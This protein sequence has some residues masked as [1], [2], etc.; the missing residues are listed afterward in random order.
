MKT[1]LTL[2]LLCC[3]GF[4]S[5]AQQPIYN[6]DAETI[7]LKTKMPKDWNIST[8]KQ[9]MLAYQVKLDPSVK[10][11]GQTSISIEKTGNQSQFSTISYFIPK[12]FQGSTI[13]LRGYIKM[14]KIDS[15]FVGLFLRVDGKDGSIAFDNMAKQELKGTADWKAYKI[16]LP[17]DSKAAKG[18]LLG[19]I[20]VGK[21]KVWFDDLQLFIDGKSID[22]VPVQEPVLVK[23]ELDTAYS[24]SSGI[25]AFKPDAKTIRNLAIAGQYWGFLKYHHPAIAKGDYNW[26][27]EL[28][29]FLP[30]VIAAKSNQE[31]SEVLEKQLDKLPAPSAEGNKSVKDAVL[32]PDYGQLFSGSVLSKSLVDKLTA[33]KNSKRD[34]SS[35][36]LSF[37]PGTGNPKFENERSYKEMTYPDAG[38]RILSLYRYWAM[39]NYF[40]PYKNIIPT[41]WNKE[42]AIALPD[43]IAAKD[44]Q[45]YLLATLKNLSKIKDT[46][47]GFWSQ[48]EAMDQFKGKYKLPF[49]ATFI[50]NKLVVTGYYG[51]TLA[52]QQKFLKG[53][54]I[55]SINGKSISHLIK[56]FLPYTAASN[57]DTQ[58]RDLPNTFLLRGNTETFTIELNRAGK[59]LQE[60]IK[61]VAIKYISKEELGK[62]KIKEGFK[63]LSNEVGYIYP[64]SYKNSDL[65]AIKAL[66]KDTKGIIVDMR[67][68]PAEFMPFSFGNYIKPVPGPFAKFSNGNLSQPGSFTYTDPEINGSLTEPAYAGKVVVIVNA[69]SQSQAEYT[70][71]AFQSSANVKVIGSTTA[72]ADGNVSAIFLPGGIKTMI[73]GIGVFYP[74]GTPTQQVGVKIDYPIKPTIKGTIAGKDELMD[75]AKEILAEMIK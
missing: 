63:L 12:T 30:Q 3:T 16:T 64:A 69:V 61:G 67:C 55:S 26:D 48:H 49:R 6:I 17:Y 71:M 24:K 21:G 9:Q 70:T 5:Q 73:S 40:F 58:L 27:A 10:K 44:A 23:A 66:F 29:R 59:A 72:G 37:E 11:A 45:E 54:V 4:I 20:M 43:F 28:F 8:D 31:L 2:F 39:I 35:Y 75:K 46:H 38:Y 15:G 18:I 57:Y 50:E 34:S 41:D 51:D 14:E 52:V 33:V 36:Y 25:P 74:D 56:T 32:K 47:G 7:D 62:Y 22:K 60:Q 13:E 68:Y 53:D 65:P 19:A 1:C 42:L